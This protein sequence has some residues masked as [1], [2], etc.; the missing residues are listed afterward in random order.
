[1]T[2]IINEEK[3]LAA[4]MNGR[5]FLVGVAVDGKVTLTLV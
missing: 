3:Y 5:G 2:T 4:K 1:M